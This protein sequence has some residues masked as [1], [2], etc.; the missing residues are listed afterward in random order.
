MLRRWQF[1]LAAAGAGDYCRGSVSLLF[2]PEHTP[3][4]P[5]CCRRRRAVPLRTTYTRRS[6]VIQ[7]YHIKTVVTPAAS[8]EV[9]DEWEESLWTRGTSITFGLKPRVWGG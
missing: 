8:T 1:V 9:A 6:G 2:A 3:A 5:S 4:E 7:D